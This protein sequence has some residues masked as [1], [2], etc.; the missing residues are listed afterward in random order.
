MWLFMYWFKNTSHTQKKTFYILI[1]FFPWLYTFDT[2]I[3]SKYCTELCIKSLVW[4]ILVKWK[5]TKG[6]AKS[7]IEIL[8]L[9]DFWGVVLASLYLLEVSLVFWRLS[10]DCGTLLNLI[11]VPLFFFSPLGNSSII[12]YLIWYLFILMLALQQH[13]I[14]QFYEKQQSLTKMSF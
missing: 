7:G 11:R 4:N 10:N 14:F 13:N 5:A 3:W 2:C 8:F 6:L 9:I 1:F 12:S